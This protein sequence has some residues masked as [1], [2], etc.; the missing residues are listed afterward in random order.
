MSELPLNQVLCEICSITIQRPPSKIVRSKHHYCS[1]ECYYKS[2]KGKKRPKHA[3]KMKKHWETHQHPMLGK[4]FSEESRKKMSESW[5]YSKSITPE[6][7]KKLSLSRMGKL[8]PNWK[9]GPKI[10][11]DIKNAIRK[12][13][14]YLTW[15]KRVFERDNYTCQSCNGKSIK[16][17][18]LI[19]EAHHISSFTEY[20]NL[21]Y[22]VD[23]GLTLCKACH[24]EV[25]H[26]S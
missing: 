2:R 25:H 6:R 26:G 21:R 4:K 23:N 17:H 14:K 13:S 10:P 5:S 24:L 1:L 18:P 11:K 3:K 12:R 15:R 16:N 20:P 9:G 19:V 22:N 7:N 8:N